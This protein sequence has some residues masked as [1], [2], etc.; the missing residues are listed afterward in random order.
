MRSKP[1]AFWLS[2]TGVE[3]AAWVVAC[4]TPV[5]GLIAWLGAPYLGFGIYAISVAVFVGTSVWTTI[6][7]TT[8]ADV[9]NF[10]EGFGNF[11]KG[12]GCLLAALAGL[13]VTGWLAM[14][15][16]EYV[17]DAGVPQL[18]RIVIVLL[19]VL[20]VAVVGSRRSA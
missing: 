8:G 19:A 3:R 20:I 10:I 16:Y 4:C 5:A 1:I 15:G 9:D 12:V 6:S 17:R 13:G 11:L 14:L 2:K 18:L 7:R